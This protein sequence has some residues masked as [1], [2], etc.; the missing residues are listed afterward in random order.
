MALTLEVG[1][2]SNLDFLCL[3]LEAL[4][5][6]EVSVFEFTWPEST[7][8]FDKDDDVAVEEVVGLGDLPRFFRL[9]CR[10]RSRSREWERERERYRE[11]ELEGDRES[12]LS[13][14]RSRRRLLSLGLSRDR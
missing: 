12:S 6:S 13:P 11:R 3:F 1:A 8:G 9:E 5:S 4:L 2:E 10:P 7:A 14:R